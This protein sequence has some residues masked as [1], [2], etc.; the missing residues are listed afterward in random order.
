MLYK[1]ADIK[2]AE[3]RQRK[4]FSPNALN[5][6][7]ES[8]SRR[9][10][11]SPIVIHSD[12]LLIAGE[13]R[14]RCALELKLEEVPVRIFENLSVEDQEA[15]QLEENVRRKDLTWQEEAKAYR[16]IYL[17]KKKQNPAITQAETADYLGVSLSEFQR[18]LQVSIYLEKDPTKI[19]HCTTLFAACSIINRLR[20]R[21]IEK[22]ASKITPGVSQTLE[23]I[24]STADI[25]DT[26]VAETVKRTI[27]QADSNSIFQG[28]F[29]E[30]SKTY[31]GPP[32]NF[33]HFDP[34]YGIN[35][36]KSDQMQ[37]A[38]WGAYNDSEETFWQ[39]TDALFSY[40]AKSKLI[41][42][43]AH[44]LFWFSM[45]YYAELLSYVNSQDG[46]VANPFPLIW[47]KSD[48][49]GVLPDPRRGPRR[50]Y[51]TAL[52]ISRAD[53]QIV[54]PINNSHSAPLG[55][56][57]HLSEKPQPVLRYFFQMFLDETSTVFDPTCGSGN[58]LAVA[59]E[60]KVKHLL[61]MDIDPKSV[62][63]AQASLRKARI[64]KKMAKVEL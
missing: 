38:N 1:T 5:Y 12:G 13:R 55:N 15:I 48:G 63:L 27:P 60:Y 7:R 36:N 34:P 32:F 53:R 35:I 50:T 46:F 44:I 58:A 6:L 16:K 21:A 64:Y 47:T 43:S 14:L 11:I 29:V 23:T 37:S 24:F 49:S 25:A 8:I 62:E 31:D 52:L 41:A 45:E 33:I 10:I 61:G 22:E 4:E 18:A 17:I 42:Q 3:D 20:D 26:T 54:K 39:L 40:E 19:E 30:W 57:V 56:K 59:E 28:D 9:G 51:E 2:V